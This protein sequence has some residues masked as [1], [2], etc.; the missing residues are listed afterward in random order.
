MAEFNRYADACERVAEKL[1]RLSAKVL[2]VGAAAA[3]PAA[4]S[5]GVATPP[6]GVSGTLRGQ[7]EADCRAADICPACESR[8][9]YCVE[10]GSP[11]AVGC[12][13]DA[14]DYVS[15][16]DERRGTRLARHEVESDMVQR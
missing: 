4:V 14:H 10:C 3:P 6:A 7:H 12:S 1:E 15:R 8:D 9:C 16:L 5:S 2:D 11:C 13:G